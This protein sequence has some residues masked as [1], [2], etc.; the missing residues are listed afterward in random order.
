M[1]IF[2]LY[3]MDGSVHLSKPEEKGRLFTFDN[4]REEAVYLWKDECYPM[5][6]P[7]DFAVI[8]IHVTL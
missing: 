6:L 7:A 3:W 4:F 5:Y 1:Q 2:V 8:H